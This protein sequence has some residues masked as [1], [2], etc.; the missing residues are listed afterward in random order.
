M[1]PAFLLHFLL[2]VALSVAATG[3]ASDKHGG[4]E[5]S[6]GKYHVELVTKDK[7]LALYVRD[8]SDKPIDPKSVKASANVLSGKDKAVVDL[9]AS[10]EKLS[11]Q[12]PFSVAKTPR[13]SSPSAWPAARASRRAFLL[14]RRLNTRDTSTK[15]D[16]PSPARGSGSAWTD[17]DLWRSFPRDRMGAARAA[18]V[19]SADTDFE[20]CGRRPYRCGRVRAIEIAPGSC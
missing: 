3:W 18:A 4:H 14:A 8:Q 12:A 7:D 6:A 15:N 11:G 20:R 5:V 10:G 9:A 2:A 13:S 19:A 1:K 17:R 16:L